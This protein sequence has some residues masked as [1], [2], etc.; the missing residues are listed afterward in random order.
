METLK[1]II[2]YFTIVMLVFVIVICLNQI[3]I[4]YQK[5]E[6]SLKE[7]FKVFKEFYYLDKTNYF[8]LAVLL[9][10]IFIEYWYIELLISIILVICVIFKRIYKIDS[11]GLS[12][13]NIWIYLITFVLYSVLGTLISLVFEFYSLN[14][15]LIGLVVSLPVGLILVILIDKLINLKNKKKD[16][17]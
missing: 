3:I 11:F 5:K 12:F 2:N 17:I 10:S 8:L 15:L 6:C 1:L 16:G 14:V 7:Y 9:L 13:K 4:F